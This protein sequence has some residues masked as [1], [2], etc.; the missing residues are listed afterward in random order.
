MNAAAALSAAAV[1]ALL[2]AV[3][4]YAYYRG[5][6]VYDEFI[7]GAREGLLLSWRLLPF[8]IAMMTSVGLFLHGGGMA[9]VEKIFAPVCG[10]FGIP[11]EVLPL[12]LTR[13][14]SGSGSLGLT[15]A[16]LD[17]YG[18]DS[19]VGRL[20]SVAQ[21][22]TETTFYVLTVYFGAVNIRRFRYAL[23]VGLIGDITAFFAAFYLTKAFFPG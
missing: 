21:G 22:S 19:F 12:A 4:L 8:L 17:R 16:L 23:W 14:L 1:P 18:A 3:P 7:D 9:L 11:G 6:P 5:V 10:V 2:I 20:A 15:A 13:P